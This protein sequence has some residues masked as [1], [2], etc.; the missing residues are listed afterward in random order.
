MP[1]PIFLS[2]K[3]VNKQISLWPSM[4]FAI[5]ELQYKVAKRLITKG[6]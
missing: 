1:C 6:R 5:S 3:T 2:I 4:N